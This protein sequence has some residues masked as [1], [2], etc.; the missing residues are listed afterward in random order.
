MNE[1]IEFEKQATG[2]KINAQREEQKRA[3]ECIRDLVN[4]RLKEFEAGGRLYET[5]TI[6]AYALRLEKASL[7][8]EGLSERMQMLELLQK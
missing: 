3:L 5:Q 2:W 8:L 6:T 4:G 1:R 7:Q